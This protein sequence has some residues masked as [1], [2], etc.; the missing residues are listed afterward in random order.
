MKKN[1]R[2][3]LLL[4]SMLA[5][6]ACDEGFD[7]LNINQTAATSVNPVFSLNNSVI[8][9]SFV[10]TTVQYEIGIV[11]QMISPN[12]GVLTGANFN[13]D[14]RDATQAAWQRYYRSTIRFAVDV[15]L[16]TKDQPTRSNLYNMAR[17]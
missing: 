8:N 14:N 16:A 4:L 7:E 13:Q 15:I 9:A 3:T 5:M 12:S 6:V 10:A 2:Y 17:I 11:Q 1:F